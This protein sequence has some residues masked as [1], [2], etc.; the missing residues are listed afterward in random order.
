MSTAEFTQLLEN[1]ILS[2]DANI[3]L[4]S[5]TQLK[6]FSNENFVQYAGLLSQVLIEENSRVEPR[7]LA[8]LNLKN[9]LISKDSIKNSQFA[10]RWSQQID[11][12]SRS[13][14]KQNALAALTSSEPR[15]ANASAQLIAAIADIELPQNEWQDL[16]KIMVDHTS[17]NQSENSRRAA[18]LT[19]GY[20]CE[21]A[22]PQSQALVSASN[23]ILIAIAQC[24]QATEPSRTVRLAALNALADSLIF[25]KNNMERD[26]ERNYLMQI[27][28]EATQADDV[29]IQAASFGCL[30]KIMSL[31][32]ALMKPYMEQALYA[33][34][35]AT[36]ESKDDKVASMTVEFWS[37]VCEEEIDIAYE[38]SQFPESPLQ[39]YNFALSSLKDVVPN[40][41][42]LLTRQNEDPEDD[43]WNVAMSAGACL[44]LYAQN[45]GDSILAPVLEFVEQNIT[46]ENWRNREAAVMAFGSIMDGP[47][48]TQTTFYVHQA[49]PAILN[50]MH[51]QTL[52]V[53]D[54]ASWCIGR[55][56]DL[57]ALAIDPQQHLPGV[58]NACLTGLQDHPKVATNCSWTIINLTEQLTEEKPSPIYNY[59]PALVDGLIKCSNRADNEFNARAS[60]F[61]A[62]TTMV[63]FSSDD[64][65]ETS[66][67]I[68]TYVLDKLGQTM[69]VNEEQ[70]NLEDTQG[71][72]ELQSN[73]LTVLAAVIRKSPQS[74]QGV[75]DMLMDLFIKL[76]Q[77]KD[78]SF[79]E[80][81]VFF[82]ISALSMSLGKEFQK[83]LEA[84]SPFLVKALNQVESTVAITAVGFIADISN[85]LEEDFKQY[86]G[87]FMNVLGQILSNPS[88]RKELKPAI[89]SVFGDIASNIGPDFVPYLQD[90]MALCVAAQ[91]TKPENGTLDA[92]DYNTRV[93]EAVLDA[94]VGIVGGLHD[95]PQAIYPYV[96][97][98]FQFIS[99]IADDPQLYT[100]DSTARSAVGLIGDIASMIS[101]GSIKQFYGQEA[102]TDLIK[103]TRSNPSFSQATKDVARWAR[104]QQKLQ[105][106]Q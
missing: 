50:L 19:I 6:R 73:I 30:C 77:K 64:V 24:T 63:E 38:R 84:F 56:A 8:A 75:S 29:E 20:I 101:D 2:P 54:T 23:Q 40:L 70:L 93:L 35:V 92:M 100:E 15:V 25:I 28:C 88:S 105:L 22:D 69:A 37:T 47:D 52:Q 68:S 82:A 76:L 81:D 55:I 44:Q 96:G 36:M 85:S 27:V 104:N 31:Y 60:A 12:E 62:L 26:G 43:D 49:L 5:E 41:L 7:I 45:C 32:Y 51:D 4:E 33:L 9:E 94:Y 66:A 103:K 106:S 34:T 79:I 78:A 14:I 67:S 99:L 98:I 97:T 18:L 11:L 86:A 3:R 74:I 21:S 59:Y 90:V 89:L 39:S 91:N 65:A 87:S 61:S 10:Q 53:K 83:Y 1:T 71:L 17:P 16:M 58:I 80:D 42:K 95:T 48:K 72:Q 46:S 13:Q 57:A 102:I